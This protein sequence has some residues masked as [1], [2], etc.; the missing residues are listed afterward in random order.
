MRGIEGAD[1]GAITETAGGI[2]AEG[3]GIDE[4][5]DLAVTGMAASS[6]SWGFNSSEISTLAGGRTAWFCNAIICAIR[7]EGFFFVP[8]QC[9]SLGGQEHLVSRSRFYVLGSNVHLRLDGA[10]QMNETIIGGREHKADFQTKT[11][12][13]AVGPCLITPLIPTQ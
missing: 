10:S 9:L 1:A 3:I 8:F 12:G 13:E 7:N 11:K 5:V 4:N 2:G 6:S